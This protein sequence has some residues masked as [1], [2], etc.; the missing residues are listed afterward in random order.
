LSVDEQ[1]ADRPRVIRSKLVLH[2]TE[3]KS[4]L[5]RS[6]SKPQVTKANTLRIKK[7]LM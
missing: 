2:L 5:R 1:S 6:A 7:H 4:F 3:G